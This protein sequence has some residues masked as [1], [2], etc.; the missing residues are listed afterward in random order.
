MRICIYC[1]SSAQA[2]ARFGDTAYEL[3]RLLA[4]HGVTV[5]YG[6]GG[7][8]SMGR[9][10]DGVHAEKGNIIGVMPHFMKKLEWAHREV[11]TILW[12]NDMA[13][14]KAKMLENTDA[15]VAL[16]GGCGTFEEL[17]E[18]ITLKRLGIYFKPIVIV[19]QEKFYDPLIALFERSVQERF[20]DERH[21]TMFSVVQNVSGVMEAIRTA[22]PWGPEAR[23]FARKG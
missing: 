5:V 13:E 14:R 9:L 1:A 16:P 22:H 20:M 3:G 19:N 12:T 2:P 10:A 4:A 6:G 23:Q 21:L 8:G 15:V 18:A 7:T 11:Q 17:L